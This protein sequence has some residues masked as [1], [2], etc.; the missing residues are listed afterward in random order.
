M[1][2]LL[3][4]V[5]LIVATGA[6]CDAKLQQPYNELQF[7]TSSMGKRAGNEAQEQ[8][9]REQEV[10]VIVEPYKSLIQTT[11]RYAL[12]NSRASKYLNVE[13]TMTFINNSVYYLAKTFPLL[14]VYKVVA[15][16]LVALS[17]GLFL[18]PDTLWH[19]PAHVLGLEKFVSA[20]GLSDKSLLDAVNA[21][22][23]ELMAQFGLDDDACRQRTWCHLGDTLK[24]ATPNYARA[25]LPRELFTSGFMAGQC[26]QIAVP[27]S[28]PANIISPILGSL[29]H[30]LSSW[31]NE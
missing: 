29:K 6:C 16:T 13:R 24:L 30:Q 4:V 9:D 25:R 20:S 23:E 7:K 15:L 21:R 2:K 19:N 14:L 10:P 3:L 22:T 5:L 1:G 11:A 18:V 12:T 31:S 26:E 17:I 27:E 8:A 28:C